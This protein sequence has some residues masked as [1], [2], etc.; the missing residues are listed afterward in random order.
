MATAQLIDVARA[1]RQRRFVHASPSV[2]NAPS[3]EIC[4]KLG[5]TMLGECEFE[6][7]PGHFMRCNDWRLDL[8]A[9]S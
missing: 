2:H 7:P 4:R 9:G 6:Y 5:F 8:F 1:E 3:N